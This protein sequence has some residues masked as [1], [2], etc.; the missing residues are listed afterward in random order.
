[1]GAEV[2]MYAAQCEGLRVETER[3]GREMDALKAQYLALKN[4]QQR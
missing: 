2:S 1:M 4:K 3:M